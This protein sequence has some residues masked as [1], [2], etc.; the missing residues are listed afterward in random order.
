MFIRNDKR[1]TTQKKTI[2]SVDMNVERCLNYK[3]KYFR[4]RLSD[5]LGTERHETD[6]ETDLRQI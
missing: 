3:T 4:L 6:P 2:H 1:F 5:E